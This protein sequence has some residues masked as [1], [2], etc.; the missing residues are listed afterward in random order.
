[1]KWVER[2]PERERE[3]VGEGGRRNGGKV[4]GKTK[5]RIRVAPASGLCAPESARIWNKER[6]ASRGPKIGMRDGVSCTIRKRI[7]SRNPPAKLRLFI[8]FLFQVTKGHRHESISFYVCMNDSAEN[9]LLF[10]N[11]IE[12]SG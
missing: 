5:R 2:I 3:M 6:D 12:V 8:F 4:R 1:M 9:F 10:V 7:R 11:K